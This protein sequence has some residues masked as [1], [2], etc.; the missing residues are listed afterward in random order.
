MN[1]TLLSGSEW[2]PGDP[3]EDPRVNSSARPI[4]VAAEFVTDA[5]PLELDDAQREGQLLLRAV[6][7]HNLPE[8]QRLLATG[9]V[10]DA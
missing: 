6:E 10:P 5:T 4:V 2:M 1:E 9:V 7:R 3:G 8:V